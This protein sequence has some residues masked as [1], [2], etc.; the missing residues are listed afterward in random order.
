ML[1][2]TQRLYLVLLV[3]FS[4]T[5]WFAGDEGCR[6]LL[7]FRSLAFSSRAVGFL[8]SEPLRCAFRKSA[9]TVYY[10]PARKSEVFS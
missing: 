4:L 3:S 5:E 7:L 1:P 10:L 2:R 8:K 6:H 9:M